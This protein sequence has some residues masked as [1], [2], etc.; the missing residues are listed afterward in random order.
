M[1]I[2][3]FLNLRHRI[4][5][6]LIH[7]IPQQCFLLGNVFIG[8]NFTSIV[9]GAIM[10]NNRVNRQDKDILFLERITLFDILSNLNVGTTSNSNS[11]GL[12]TVNSKQTRD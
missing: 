11:I 1:H 2:E 7:F 8:T 3:A 5:S 6:I 10:S 4:A 12:V 9:V